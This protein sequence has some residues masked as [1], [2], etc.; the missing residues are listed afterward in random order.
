MVSL[1]ASLSGQWL[2]PGAF[3]CSPCVGEVFLQPLWWVQLNQL[4]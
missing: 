3:E 2:H 1:V 4:L